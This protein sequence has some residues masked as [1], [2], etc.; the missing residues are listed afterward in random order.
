[1]ASL[2]DINLDQLSE[3]DKSELRT[4]LANE[5]QRARVQATVHSITDMCF[6]KCVTGTIRSSTLDKSEESCMANC[7]DRFLDISQV[8]VTHLQNM[9][10]S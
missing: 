8:A 10:Q 2:N 5:N 4:F 1:M 7:A 3:K 9:K 6:K